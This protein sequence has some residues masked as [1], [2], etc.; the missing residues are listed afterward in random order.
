MNNK[1]SYYNL[2]DDKP[3][4]LDSRERDHNG[5]EENNSPASHPISALVRLMINPTNGWKAFRRNKFSPEIMANKCFYPLVGIASLS[6]FTDLVYFGE[7]TVQSV[8]VDALLIF[9]SFFFGYFLTLP[10]C[11][12]FLPKEVRFFPDSDFGK[13]FIMGMLS[14]LCMFF[15]L[16]KCLPMLDTIWVFLPLWTIYLTSKGTR[17]IKASQQKPKTITF[18]LSVL[19]VGTPLAVSRIFNL[20]LP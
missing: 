11:R 17:F 18:I 7:T 1:D 5:P 16:Y 13:D 4:L 14:T 6:S 19:I 8:I 10:L 12:I 9:I 20:I 2:E 3:E 15:T